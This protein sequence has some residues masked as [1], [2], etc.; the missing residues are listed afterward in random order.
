MRGKLARALALVAA[1]AGVRA[2]GALAE[3]GC[4]TARNALGGPPPVALQERAQDLWRKTGG[5]HA[6]YDP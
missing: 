5:Q 1:L 2:L 3:Q 6:D 4:E